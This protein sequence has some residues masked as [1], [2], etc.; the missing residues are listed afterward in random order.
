MLFNKHVHIGLL[1][2][3]S[4]NFQSEFLQFAPMDDD[5][6]GYTAISIDLRSA[7]VTRFSM[8]TNT[9]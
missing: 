6:Y 7:Y 4:Y 8:H 3:D 9:R 5:I 2:F 1:K